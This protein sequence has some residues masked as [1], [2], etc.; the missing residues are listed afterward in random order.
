M[1]ALQKRLANF[2]P[3]KVRRR[4]PY[5]AMGALYLYVGYHALSGSQ[6]LVSWMEA[7]SR[8]ERLDVKL[9]AKKDRRAHLQE[10]V[11]NLSSGS[12]NLDALDI[13]ARRTLY[14][15]K[16]QEIT[17]WLDPARP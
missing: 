10:E 8:A 17:I 14:M 15:S 7:E 3:A 4:V 1:R 9:Q 2:S 6:G 5:M 13:E 16:P 11:D 12:L